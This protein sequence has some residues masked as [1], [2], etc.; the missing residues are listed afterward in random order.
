[1]C[2]KVEDYDGGLTDFNSVFENLLETEE[3]EQLAFRRMIQALALS[4]DIPNV[5][6]SF[7]GETSDE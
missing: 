6:V 4:V 1:M 2:E 3:G 5:E 7:D